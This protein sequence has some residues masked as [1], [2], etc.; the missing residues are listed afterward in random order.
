MAAQ[1][2][3]R[4]FQRADGLVFRMDDPDHIKRM[5]SEGWR[6]VDD[7]HATLPAPVAL[8]AGDLHPES[9][10]VIQTRNDQARAAMEPASAATAAP[11]LKKI[12]AVDARVDARGEGG[13]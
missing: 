10:E 5:L 12:K 2:D 13:V 8:P 7:P 6:E 3:G 4:W 11:H 1:F 9:L